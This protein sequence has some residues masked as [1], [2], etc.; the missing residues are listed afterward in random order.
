MIAK[1]ADASDE[2][3]FRAILADTLEK[4]KTDGI[5]ERSINAYLERAEFKF[6]ESAY[7]SFPKGLDLF[8]MM[9]RG[10]LYGDGDPFRY[11]RVISIIGELKKR[12]KE[13]YFESLIDRLIRSDHSV[14]LSLLP[15]PGLAEKEDESLS[16][17][18]ESF[19]KSLSTEEFEKIREDY[20]ALN[21]Y[22]DAP[23][24]DEERSCIPVLPR[25]SISADPEPISNAD[26]TVGGVPAVIHEFPSNGIVYARFLFDLSDLSADDLPYLDLLIELL[27]NCS[28]SK[29]SYRDLIDEARITT[30]GLDFDA[31]VVRKYGSNDYTP[32]LTVSLRCLFSKVAE[33]FDLLSEIVSDSDV[34]DKDRIKEI[35]GQTVSSKARDILFSGDELAAIR[36]LSY[37]NSS[38]VF[39]DM[40]EGIGSYKVQEALYS[41]FDRSY[42]D[43]SSKLSRLYRKV[44][45]KNRLL[46]SV[47]APD[48][49]IPALDPLVSR[50]VAAMSDSGPVVP[51]KLAPYGPLNEA[52]VAATQ[53]QYVAFASDVKSA[54]RRR[55]GLNLL[56]SKA[57]SG[58]ILYPEIRVKGGAYGSYC[59]MASDSAK[60]LMTSYR[61]PNLMNTV[62]VFKSIYEKLLEFRPDGEKLWQLVIGT[63]SRID[64]PTSAYQKMCRSLSCR[65]TGKTVDDLS[66][67][68]ASI[69][70]VTPESFL[71]AAERLSD[72]KNGFTLCV[73]GKGS[74]IRR[75]SSLFGSVSDIFK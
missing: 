52:F 48:D 44:F 23:E 46:L 22:I 41:D 28:T 2:E 18:L 42:D 57:A 20:E 40:T 71:K 17:Q 31:S 3:R 45:D 29:R 24:T 35:L 75:N 13:G 14:R 5:S 67:E 38:S 64:R 7:G 21:E 47:C 70:A 39:S 37:T 65:L 34:T 1:N 51:Q 43:I 27:G 68:R 73:I 25:G 59:A 15:E 55:D 56:L 8:R 69:L 50:I 53:V 60:V 30:G 49:V 32:Y 11:V 58:E 74:V 10:W 6:R 12:V 61:D 9:L 4:L 66:A 62:N 19:K 33:S 54:D 36:C 72:V 16:S 63:F 26:A